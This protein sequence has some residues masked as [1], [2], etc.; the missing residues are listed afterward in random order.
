MGGMVEIVI[1]L[2]KTSKGTHVAV[3]GHG[4]SVRYLSPD[5]TPLQLLQAFV[6]KLDRLAVL[7]DSKN[8]TLTR[9]VPTARM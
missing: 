1:C 5:M 8:P 9:D 7:P 2:R 6:Q 3:T 4:Y